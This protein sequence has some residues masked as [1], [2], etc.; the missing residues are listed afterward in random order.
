VN[1]GLV[2]FKFQNKKAMMVRTFGL[3]TQQMAGR[4]TRDNNFLQ[5]ILFFG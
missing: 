4:K 2:L 5:R 3:C 1:V